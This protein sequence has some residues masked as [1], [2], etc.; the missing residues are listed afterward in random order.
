[1]KRA[2]VYH[3]GDV[4]VML[5]MSRTTDG[6]Y[7]VAD[8]PVIVPF[9][10]SPSVIGKTLL[11]VL[12]ESKIGV[13]HPTNWKDHG[14]D[15]YEA[16]GVKRWSAFTDGATSCSI[17]EDNGLIWFEPEEYNDEYRAFTVVEGAGLSVSS[18]EPPG[19]IG[20]TLLRALDRSVPKGGTKRKTRRRKSK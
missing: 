14:R 13:P 5:A 20:A 17:E 8:K 9:N 1:M 7:I 19:Q 11:Q 10:S 12:S 3:R 6:L 16:V 18:N 2:G 4:L 15:L